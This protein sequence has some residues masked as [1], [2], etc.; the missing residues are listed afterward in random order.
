MKGRRSLR[1]YYRVGVARRGVGLV[2]ES[3]FKEGGEEAVV[4]VVSM[5]GLAAGRWRCLL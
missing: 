3:W 2:E 4:V 5:V 1:V